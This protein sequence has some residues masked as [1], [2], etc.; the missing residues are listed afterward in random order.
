[1]EEVS[2]VTGAPFASQ[3][4]QPQ[5]DCND[6]TDD[7]FHCA[8]DEAPPGG[9]DSAEPEIVGLPLGA[10]S[11]VRDSAASEIASQPLGA[12][13]D[14][15]A[16]NAADVGGSMPAS[17]PSSVPTSVPARP[18]VEAAASLVDAKPSQP[19]W[20]GF[21]PFRWL[22]DENLA[23]ANACLRA[24]HHLPEDILL[25]DPAPAFW[26]AMQVDGMQAAEAR[27]ALQLED[28]RLVLCPVNDNF[29]G[30]LADAGS[31][32]TLLV[33]IRPEKGSYREKDVFINYDSSRWPKPSSA[34]QAKA[35]ACNLAG[36]DVYVYSG[37][38]GW[39]TNGYDC[40]MYVVCF[41]DCIIQV[42]R[43]EHTRTFTRHLVFTW[44][45]RLKSVSPW[46]VHKTR[47]LMR[48]TLQSPSAGATG[49]A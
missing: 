4:P 27:K 45:N 5:K 40:G 6:V 42:F 49:G 7:I 34:K 33:W 23:Q 24:H 9:R 25:M 44:E 30:G 8:D 10:S 20:Y 22:S 29:N 19:S 1:M 38:C 41:A 16:R 39:Q 28:R 35:L 31:H 15:G 12:S 3:A 21:L 37:V 13:Y 36:K 11:D 17:V 32:W 46:E 48:E 18:A 14:R 43:Q 26:L 2:R 47:E